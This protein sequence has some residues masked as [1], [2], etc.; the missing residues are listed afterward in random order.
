MLKEYPKYK[1]GEPERIYNSLKK[2]DKKCID[3]FL[4]TISASDRKKKDMLRSI[5]QFRHVIE[6]PFN[7]IDKADLKKFIPLLDKSGREKYTVNGIKTHIK[8]FLK[9]VHEDWFSRF[10]DFKMI[11][12]VS[13]ARNEKR[14]NSKFMLT[15]EKI[16]EL[17]KNETDPRKKAFFFTLFESAVRPIE[18]R[19]LK[20]GDV[21]FGEGLTELQIF[22]TK[23]GKARV[24]FIQSSTPLLEELGVGNKDEYVFQSR[25]G[26]NKPIDRVTALRWVSSMGK[27]VGLQIYPYLLR[28]SRATDL[29]RLVK[30]GKMSS[31]IAAQIMGHSEKTFMSYGDLDK[32]TIKEM[33]RTQMYN[34]DEIPK[35]KKHELEL[36]LEK[37]KGQFAKFMRLHDEE[38]L[39]NQSIKINKKIA[40]QL[41]KRAQ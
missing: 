19:L 34:F 2:D 3:D 36:E 16:E 22:S 39:L 27:G 23:T 37:L 21:T 11:R 32:E 30:S 15:K 13:N 12:C 38:K 17:V 4:A 10:E 5:I 29:H 33:M 24:T 25:E 7:E 41:K 9:E 8:R 35:E 20:W 18:L 14:I 1:K 40:S 26:T 6:K 31:T 28:H